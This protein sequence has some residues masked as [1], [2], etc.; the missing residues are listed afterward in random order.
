MNIARLS[1]IIIALLDAMAQSVKYISPG[2][3]AG[4]PIKYRLFT[5]SNHFY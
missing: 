1:L 3:P 4:C 5:S 2:P